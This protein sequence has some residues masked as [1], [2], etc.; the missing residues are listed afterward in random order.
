MKLAERIEGES[1]L[2][3]YWAV[4][5]FLSGCTYSVH[6]IL[7]DSDLTTDVDLSGTWAL[8]PQDSDRHD[9]CRFSMQSVDGGANYRGAFDNGKEFAAR[10]GKLG[11]QRYFELSIVEHHTEQPALLSSIP[12]YAIAR[13]ETAGDTL[14]VFP[15]GHNRAIPC[16]DK[17]NIPYRLIEP[18]VKHYVLTADTATLQKLLTDHSDELFSESGFTFARKPAGTRR[19]DATEGETESAEVAGGKAEAIRKLEFLV[20]TWESVEQENAPAA[21]ETRTIALQPDGLSLT[22]TTESVLGKGR[23]V[24]ITFDLE[25]QQYLLTHTNADG[26]TRVFNAKLTDDS[27]LKIPIPESVL[28]SGLDFIVSVNDGQWTETISQPSKPSETLYQRSFLR[29]QH[30]PLKA[31]P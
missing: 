30:D 14:R 24:R 9:W 28:F 29:Q 15:I 6:P 22:V 18:G 17:H 7:R 26:D 12:V 4:A 5:L 8:K 20:G 31:K 27:K 10:I 13:F 23:P 25:S 11:D 16:F 21:P 3:W 1:V 2:R 19:T